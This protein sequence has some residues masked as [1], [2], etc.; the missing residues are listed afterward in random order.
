MASNQI[1]AL[2][3]AIRTAGINSTAAKIAYDELAKSYAAA[4]M[5][6]LLKQIQDYA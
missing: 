2:R 6:H 1:E 4:N 5:K 3:R